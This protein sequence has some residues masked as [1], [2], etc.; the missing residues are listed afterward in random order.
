MFPDKL[1][2]SSFLDRFPHYAWTVTWSA[3]SGFAGSRVYACLGVTCHLLFSQTDR[4]LLHATAVTRGWNGP[5]KSQHT[6]LTLESTEKFFFNFNFAKTA[7][8]TIFQK[9]TAQL[10]LPSEQIHSPHPPTNPMT[11]EF[12]HTNINS[13]REWCWTHPDTLC[14]FAR[15]LRGVLVS[16]HGAF[17]QGQ[18]HWR[19]PLNCA[20][21]VGWNPVKV[22]H[23]HTH[24]FVI[25]HMIMRPC[26][27]KKKK[28]S[29]L[30]NFTPYPVIVCHDGGGIFLACKDFGRKF[31]HSFPLPVHF[32][33]LCFFSGD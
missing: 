13:K 21:Q 26:G 8:W 5:N 25:C 18:Q 30:H 12:S 16:D 10:W 33:C 28:E 17:F 7:S 15:H 9:E 20:R 24:K 6:K 3:H 1:C 23:K 22:L 4:G 29:K 32:F 31:N 2:V 27:K 14:Q 11:R 19:Q